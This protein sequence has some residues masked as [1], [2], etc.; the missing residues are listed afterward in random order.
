MGNIHKISNAADKN[1]CSRIFFD[2]FYLHKYT[3]VSID[4]A[5]KSK[6]KN[7]ITYERL[8]RHEHNFKMLHRKIICL[9]N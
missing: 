6:L 8:F 3:S 7:D 1:Q 2:N 5:H 4:R 9:P